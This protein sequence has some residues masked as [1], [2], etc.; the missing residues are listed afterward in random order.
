MLQYF[1]HVGPGFCQKAIAVDERLV[2][3]HVVDHDGATLTHAVLHRYGLTS[4][5]QIDV[6]R[7]EQADH[8]AGVA[9]TEKCNA[10]VRGDQ[11]ANFV[12][13]FGYDA[14][15]KQPERWIGRF[16]EGIERRTQPFQASEFSRLEEHQ[17]VVGK[18]KFRSLAGALY[19][20]LPVIERT[21]AQ[22]EKI[23]PLD[24][25]AVGLVD[26]IHRF[27][28][29]A[30]YPAICTQ[31]TSQYGT[32]ISAMKKFT[33]EERASAII[34]VFMAVDPKANVRM[35]VY[36]FFDSK[37]F[38]STRAVKDD[39]IRGETANSGIYPGMHAQFSHDLLG[40]NTSVRES[41]NQRS[42]TAKVFPRVGIGYLAS[43]RH[44]LGRGYDS[45]V[46]T[47]RNMLPDELVLLIQD[48]V[49]V[50]A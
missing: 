28:R 8:L 29:D 14:A 44:R 23:Q 43:F 9:P 34:G 1:R 16:Q 32:V 33:R 11:T 46:M 3:F 25:D 38:P 21:A 10:G 7:G 5:L 18:T 31:C 26:E 30:Q 22:W 17:M 36:I 27:E 45:D 20:V 15:E 12:G 42:V 19:L 37:Q 50:K 13:V 48:V 40:E 41:L 24:R 49:D 6:C 39:N 47:K 4:R 2:A 35:P